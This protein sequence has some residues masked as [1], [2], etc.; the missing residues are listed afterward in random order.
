[1]TECSIQHFGVCMQHPMKQKML[2]TMSIIAVIA[3]FIAKQIQVVLQEPHRHSVQY[4][5]TM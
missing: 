1:M 3:T 2:L 4:T 5:A